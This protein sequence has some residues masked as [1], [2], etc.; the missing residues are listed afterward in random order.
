MR[1]LR[2][3]TRAAVLVALVLGCGFS[4]GCCGLGSDDSKR[5]RPE[6]VTTEYAP[7]QRSREAKAEE[8][9]L[10]E[11]RARYAAMAPAQLE[12]A[13]EGA[14]MGTSCDAE[15][16][17]LILAAAATTQERTKLERK[18]TALEAAAA[19]RQRSKAA[20]PRRQEPASTHPA[21]PAP[22]PEPAG[23]VCCCDGTVSPTCTTVHRGCCSRHGG[24]CACN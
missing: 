20:P 4:G 3:S 8:Q 19:A 1:S 13:L 24:V 11:R 21:Q 2:R 14:C 12:S 7:S 16:T 15:T 17:K 6:P 23:R 10:A 18:L 22:R 5:R 9:Q